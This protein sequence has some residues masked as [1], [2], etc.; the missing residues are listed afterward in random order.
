[1][2]TEVS[3]S[4]STTE[5]LDRY[6]PYP[7]SVVDRFLAWVDRLPVPAWFF[8]LVFLIT[9]II[10]FNGLAWIDGSLRFPALEVYRSS[11]PVYPVA[12]LALVYYL[13]RVARR[14]LAAFRPAL[15]VGEA[16]YERLEYMLVN[17]P[18]RG[19]WAT[20]A[21]SLVFTA[22]YINFTPYLV[23]L[24]RRSPWV[25]LVE[26]VVYAFVFG[27]IAVFLYHIIWQLRMVSRI[28]SSATNI[29]LFR[30]TP[31]YAFSNL[32]A[33]T[34]ISLLLMNYFGVLTDPATFENLA[35]TALTIAASLVGVVCFILPLRGIHDRIVAEKNRLRAQCSARLETTIEQ[36]YDRADSQDL[37]EV[38]RLN[39]LMVSLVTTSEIIEKIPTWPWEPGT[40][41]TF[42]SVFLLPFIVGLIVEIVS[43]LLP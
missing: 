22:A 13:N 18:R 21:L 27:M 41:M 31:L 30:R 17:L 23:S 1:M 38:D 8:Y 4:P 28:H 10:V 19:T 40:L 36:L 15:G 9:L 24:F 2:T 20:L 11:V 37:V 29:N 43:R 3:E 6:P 32:T 16:E 12:S 39:Q 35:L 33:Q 14:A 5:R 42:I 26:F 34:G 7:A 25:A